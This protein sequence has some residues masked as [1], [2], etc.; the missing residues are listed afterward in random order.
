MALE[1]EDVQRVADLAAIAITDEEA[2]GFRQDLASLLAAF[3]KLLALDVSDVPPTAC[4]ALGRAPLRSDE[5]RPSLPPETA[6][7]NAPAREGTN[8]LVP[9][10]IE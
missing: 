8:F 6:L 3:D 1:R 5:A 9:R 10:I 4:A 2:E 7:A